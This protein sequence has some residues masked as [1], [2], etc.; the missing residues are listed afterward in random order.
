MKHP[1]LCACF[2]FVFCVV[3]YHSG[4]RLNAAE[5]WNSVGVGK[6]SSFSSSYYVRKNKRDSE[7]KSRT[8]YNATKRFNQADRHS[9]RRVLFNSQDP[10][11]VG[12]GK[13][14]VEAAIYTYKSIRL[15]EQRSSKQF[16]I[17]SA[18]AVANRQADIDHALQ[19]EY[20]RRKATAKHMIE[21]AR[22]DEAA[23]FRAK[24]ARQLKLA[25][26]EAEKNKRD[27]ERARKKAR[28]LGMAGAYRTSRSSS[29]NSRRKVTRKLLP[30]SSSSAVKLKKPARLFND[31]NR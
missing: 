9:K 17:M 3:A 23:R 13:G 21:V 2:T 26:I 19:L 12:S 4:I 1:Y 20:E 5:L 29:N 14:R 15:R 10:S 7:K 27:E 24:K 18:D 11:K 30:P 25:S 6:S 22:A 28:A 31:P 8:L 16:E